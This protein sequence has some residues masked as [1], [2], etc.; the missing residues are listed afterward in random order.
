MCIIKHIMQNI[1]IK[2]SYNVNFTFKI[3]YALGI[4]FIVM[5]HCGGG[6]ISIVSEFFPFCVFHLAIFM[7]ASGF[8]Y[9]EKNES[10][11]KQY[12]F[13]KI[14][15]LIIPLY[16]W[17]FFYAFVIHTIKNFG[18][19][20]NVH[21]NLETLFLTPIM[22]GHQFVLNLA[23]WFV[24]PLFM[25][26]VINILIRKI[27]KNFKININEIVYFGIMLIFGFIGVILSNKGYDKNWFLV[28]DRVLYF[29]PFY[30]LGILYK[31]YEQFDRLNNVVYFGIIFSIALVLIYH[32]NCMP[33]ITPSWVTFNGM[34]CFTPFIEGI[35]GIAF[36][37][38]I[39][40]ILTP[41][42]GQSKFI[43]TIADN[44]YTIMINHCAG[45][46][47]L[48]TIFALISKYTEYCSNFNFSAYKTHIFYCYIPHNLTQF[49][50]LY[51]IAG[52]IFSIVF[53]Q[54]IYK[55]VAFCKTK[56]VVSEQS[57]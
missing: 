2:S 21:V 52:I 47:L 12:I 41:A 29:L 14:K 57:V 11:V 38:R 55:V 3:I 26:H 4:I 17:N 5:G 45:F 30:S 24:I 56:M 7:F 39:S 42:I 22:H 54:A 34:C 13:N 50:V 51:V 10:N 8:F 48:K 35:L 32:Y 53:Q 19:F 16:L 40:K 1:D 46:M 33:P 27:L 9:K 15:R 6:G 31:K 20:P 43:N 23:G 44:T 28:L 49:Y 37:L 25:I 36:W 18:F